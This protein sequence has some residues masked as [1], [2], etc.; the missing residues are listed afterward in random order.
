M[1]YK[2]PSY[3]ITFL[4]LI[5]APLVLFGAKS[6]LLPD[7][8]YSK[9]EDEWCTDEETLSGGYLKPY[10]PYELSMPDEADLLSFVHT[11]WDPTIIVSV[12][13]KSIKRSCRLGL[14]PLAVPRTRR[15][16][17]NPD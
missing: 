4:H 14:L 7:E 5:F 8:D 16:R 15:S 17:A 6:V 9:N 3:I 2:K 12:L 1:T 11:K 10:E 13:V